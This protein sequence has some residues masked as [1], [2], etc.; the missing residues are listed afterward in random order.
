MIV[1]GK[2]GVI[3]SSMNVMGVTNYPLVR[4]KGCSTEKKTHVRYCNL[5][6][7]LY[8][9]S[10]VRV[11]RGEPIAFILLNGHGIKMS[12]KYLPLYPQANV[13]LNPHQRRIFV[14]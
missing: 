4:F 9:A 6:K 7:N 10:V 5:F 14:R 12:S 13:A 2:T 8:V 11:P 3:V 1:P